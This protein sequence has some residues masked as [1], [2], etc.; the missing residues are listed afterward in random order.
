[1]L[2]IKLKQ[3]IKLIDEVIISKLGGRALQG[4]YPGHQKICNT[5]EIY[6][7]TETAS[8]TQ[9]YQYKFQDSLPIASY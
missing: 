5:L 2:E 1:M 7:T 9:I 6:F 4:S 3:R 8:L